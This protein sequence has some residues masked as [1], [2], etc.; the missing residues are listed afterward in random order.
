MKGKGDGGAAANLDGLK[1]A[2]SNISSIQEDEVP[3]Y[4][5]PSKP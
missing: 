1:V 5:A 2:R 3:P 4:T